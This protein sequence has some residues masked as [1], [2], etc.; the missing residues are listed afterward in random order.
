MANSPTPVGHAEPEDPIGERSAT[1]IRAFLS[2][3]RPMVANEVPAMY[4]E[5]RA[6]LESLALS[7]DVGSDCRWEASQCATVLD[8]MSCIEPIPGTC[9]CNDDA[10]VNA[11]CGFHVILDF[12]AEQLRSSGQKPRRRKE[13]A[14]G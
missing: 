13:V 8:F 5:G 6:Q 4:W 12:M 14:H 2:R 7:F 11:T 10:A 1:R 9:F 3:T